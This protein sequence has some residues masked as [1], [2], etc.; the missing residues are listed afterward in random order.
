MDKI[1]DKILQ[2]IYAAITIVSLLGLMTFI[3]LFNHSEWATV[4]DGKLRLQSVI[5]YANVTTV[6]CGIGVIL[7]YLFIKKSKE[8]KILHTFCMIINLM[9]LLLTFSRFGIM[10]FFVAI[11]LIL[12]LKYKWVRR[13]TIVGLIFVISTVT[14]IFITGR[15]ELLLG[16]TLVSRLIYW[17]DGF[18]LWLKNPLGIGAGSWESAQYKVQTTGYFVKFVH[19]SFLQILLDSGII[20]LTIFLIILTMCFKGL[21]YRWKQTKDNFYLGMLGIALFICFH[22]IEVYIVHA[23]SSSITPAPRL[24]PIVSPLSEETLE[25]NELTTYDSNEEKL[26]STIVTIAKGEN[27]V[28]YS[29]PYFLLARYRLYIKFKVLNSS[30]Y[31]YFDTYELN[32]PRESQEINVSLVKIVQV[33][34]MVYLPNDT[35]AEKDII[36][37]VFTDNYSTYATI[38]EGQNSG[39]YTLTLPISS[40][41]IVGYRTDDDTSEFLA[42]YYSDNETVLSVDDADSI[43]VSTNNISNIDM[44]LRLAPFIRGTITL[45]EGVQLDEDGIGLKIYA[46]FGMTNVF[47]AQG[48]KSVPYKLY[49]QAETIETSRLRYYIISSHNDLWGN[50]YYAEG[51]A[52]TLWNY[53]N[54]ILSDGGNIENIDFTLIKSVPLTGQIKL[55]ED[56]IADNDMFGNVYTQL[57]YKPLTTYGFEPYDIDIET[58]NDDMPQK[59]SGDSSNTFKIKTAS[60]LLLIK[61][62]QNSGTYTAYLPEDYYLSGY[63]LYYRLRNNQEYYP[64]GYYSYKGTTALYDEADMLS[65]SDKNTTITLLDK[66]TISGTISRPE[67]FYGYINLSLEILGVRDNSFLY[68]SDAYTSTM[69][70]TEENSISYSISVPANI[71]K[72]VLR[73]S[74]YIDEKKGFLDEIAYY[75]SIGIVKDIEDAE[76]LTVNNDIEDIDFTLSTKDIE[77]GLEVQI[78]NMSNSYGTKYRIRDDVYSTKKFSVSLQNLSDKNVDGKV[79]VSVYDED[80]RIIEVVSSKL[81]MGDWSSKEINMQFKNYLPTTADK[82]KVK[83]W[84]NMCPL[85]RALVIE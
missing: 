51:S 65:L 74:A 5:G 82:I 22:A 7:A 26:F 16:T 84:D 57:I 85:G 24:S 66:N 20:A 53:A 62:G 13:V 3:G 44:E 43:E 48:Q 19:N 31:S 25:V 21:Y 50:G 34:G 37:Q 30:S 60:E 38:K 54:S 83:V 28:N 18:F 61:A 39:T 75:N 33:T 36:V 32:D 11:A 27:S 46:D 15:E 47:I 14:Y 63:K 35:E 29:L 17:Y 1:N 80:N 10:F 41:Y 2:A 67:N 49:I 72:C 23:K 40:S 69:F 68:Q 71:N 79:F 78:T 9:G 6:F 77:E 4:I 64:M 8:T 56:R 81:E 73:Y 52:T 45:P 58:E 76:I 70:S 55:P 42:G 12:S 59:S